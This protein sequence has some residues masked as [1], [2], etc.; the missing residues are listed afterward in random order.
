MP[1][2]GEFVEKVSQTGV[3]SGVATQKAIGPKGE[4]VTFRFLRRGEGPVVI[5]PN[6]EET[7]RLTPVQLSSLCRQLE[8][9][10]TPFGLTLGFLKDPIGF[11]D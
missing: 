5:L 4:E 1:S 2:L 7:D 11:W 6:I 10:P 9:D 8:I 3:N